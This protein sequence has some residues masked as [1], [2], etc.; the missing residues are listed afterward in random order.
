M[1]TRQQQAQSTSRQKEVVVERKLATLERIVAVKPIDGADAIEQIVVRGWNVVAKKGE[2]AVGD[3]CVY[4]EIDSFLPVDDERFAFLAPRGTKTVDG[5]TGHVLRTAKLRGVYSQGLAVKV[6]AFPELAEMLDTFETDGVDLS[7]TLGV[8][9]WEAPIPAEL[10]GVAVGAFP[11]RFAPK[12]DA[13]RVQNLVDIYNKLTA[14]QWT[15]TEKIDGTS[16]TYIRDGGQLRV[17]SRNLELAP[18]TAT[19]WR[20]AETLD[21]LTLLEDGDALQGEL[22]GEGI[23]SNPLNKH[24]QHFRAFALWRNRQLVARTDW[25]EQLRELA[26]PVYNL[27]FPTS[28]ETAITQ[29]D[30][31]GSLVTPGK[32]AEG[33]V[34]H[35]TNGT[36]FDELDGRGCFK[37][38]SNR[39]LMK[40]Q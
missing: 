27:E 28:V 13:E 39:W 17:C 26:A 2:F 31:I 9:K 38:I 12:T 16:V 36:T 5:K 19:S 33:I 40:N 30:G 3:L 23:Q 24:G 32:L 14:T 37:V 29:A 18:G 6:D 8:S 22:F 1:S 11:T 35:T 34:W 10:A 7:A 20:I 21:I 4:F 15:A 25:P